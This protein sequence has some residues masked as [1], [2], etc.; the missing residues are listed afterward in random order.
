MNCL[1]HDYSSVCDGRSTAATW[2]TGAAASSDMDNKRPWWA[3][4]CQEPFKAHSHN[5][6]L[7]PHQMLEG[8]AALQ[9]F[10]LCNASSGM[11]GMGGPTAES[12]WRSGWA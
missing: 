9:G 3:Y 4:Q 10:Q 5:Y 7:M 12:S 6:R 11:P 8:L 2:T 1:A